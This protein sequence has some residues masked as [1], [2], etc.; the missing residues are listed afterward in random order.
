MVGKLIR[1]RGT[2][3]LAASVGLVA[4]AAWAVRDVPA[5]LGSAPSGGRA[6]RLRRSPQYRD[7]AFHNRLS[8]HT[9]PAGSGG[10]LLRDAF[11]GPHRRKPSGPVPLL[12]PTTGPVPADALHVIWYGHS[13]ALV[14]IE[15]RRV[16]FDP[17]WSERCSPSML[18]GPRRLHPPPVPLEELPELDAIVI[19]HDHYDHLDMATV[20]TLAREQTAPFLIPLGVGGHLERWG[21]PPHRIIELDWDESTTIGDL[22][23]TATQAR[24]FSGRTLRRD[25][26]LWASWVLTGRTHRLFYT[27]DSGYFDGYAGIGAQYGPFDATLMQIGAYS[28]GWPEIHMTPEEAIQAHR[29]LG[30]GLLIP[31]HWATFVLAFHDWADPVERLWREAKALDVRLAIPRPGERVDIADP[32]PVDGWWQSIA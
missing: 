18:A 4:A 8:T 1:S 21:L 9:M 29:D 19:S 12:T 5:A 28:P 31:L 14:E 2:W 23:L 17:V 16:L 26:T 20:R 10:Q 6:E 22:R 7:G 27:G 30:G 25:T 3:G 32:P 13:S 11:V 15:G 24:H